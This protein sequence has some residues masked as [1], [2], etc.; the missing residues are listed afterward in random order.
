MP[1]SV[2]RITTCSPSKR[3]MT[4]SA[5]ASLGHC[6][7][8]VLPVNVQ[9]AP[10]NHNSVEMPSHPA[11]RIGAGPGRTASEQLKANGLP[12]SRRSSNW[13]LIQNKPAF[14][15]EDN[16]QQRDCLSISSFFLPNGTVHCPAPTFPI[17]RLPLV[18]QR[19]L[20]EPDYPGYLPPF[21]PSRLC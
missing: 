15:A 6:A 8:P 3:S 14:L 21:A 13:R 5:V 1:V 10:Q 18:P 11:S 20:H 2:R 17:I 9:T 4:K 7:L 19:I 12:G 16:R